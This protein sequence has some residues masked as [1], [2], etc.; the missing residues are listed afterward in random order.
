MLAVGDSRVAMMM[1]SHRFLGNSARASS[2]Q[3]HQY[4][5]ILDS[6][7]YCNNFLPTGGSPT[8]AQSLLKAVVCSNERR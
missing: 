1:D 6:G 4:D 5:N 8:Y 2:G 7:W 3:R